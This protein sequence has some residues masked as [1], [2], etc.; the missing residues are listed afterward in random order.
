MVGEIR[1]KE[2]AETALH[3]AQTGHLVFSTL[4]TNNAVGGFTRLIDLDI[5]PQILGTS[6]NLILGQRL[7]R[8]LCEHCKQSYPASTNEIKTIQAIMDRHPYPKDISD[9]LQLYKPMG[10]KECGNTGFKGRVGVFEGVLMDEAVEEVVVR[11]PREH[12]ILEAAKP[13][14]IPSMLEDGIEKVI[15]GTSSI[16]ELKRVVEFPRGV[17]FLDY[18]D[19]MEANQPMTP[20]TSD[21]S[22]ED[23][24]EHIV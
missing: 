2:V 6:I 17:N 22:D 13:Q 10:C 19:L 15:A 9:S 18:D 21:I 4:H 3:A 5:N 14:K 16:T 11:D 20:K 12:A 23:F 8:V 7:I 1:D 24:A